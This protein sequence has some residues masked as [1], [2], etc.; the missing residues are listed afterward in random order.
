LVT[1]YDGV[2]ILGDAPVSDGVATLITGLL[3]SGARSLTALYEGGGSMPYAPIVSAVQLQTVNALA[4]DT[5]LASAPIY[6]GGSLYL[7]D[8]VVVNDF[9]GDG[10]QDLA[11]LTSHTGLV[12]FLGNGSGGFTPAAGGPYSVG[13]NPNGIVA[14]DFNGDGIPDLA[15]TSSGNNNMTVLLGNG[16]GTFTAAS[17]SPFGVGSYPQGLAVGDFNGDGIAD[18][19]IAASSSYQVTVLL[20]NGTGGFTAASGSPIAVNYPTAVAVADFNGDGI[21]DI[22]VAEGQD[23][24]VAVFLGNGQGGFTSAGSPTPVGNVPWAMVT[25]DFNGDGKADLAVINYEG[26]NVTVLLGNGTGG[27]AQSTG[28]P[29]EVGPYPFTIASGDF[30]GD[31][32][33]DLAVSI[34]GNNGVAILLGNGSGGFTSPAYSP[35][36]PLVGGYAVAVGQFNGDGHTDLAVGGYNSFEIYAA[37]AVPQLQITHQPSSGT[38]GAA[39]GNVVVQVNDVNGNLMTGSTAQITLSSN[40]AGVGGTVTVNASGG[41][42]TFS[43]LVFSAAG[44]FVLT[45]SSPGAV[46][47]PAGSTIQIAAGSQTISF[48]AISSQSMGTPVTL[49]AT[50]SSG[51]TVNFASL[52]STVCAVSGNTATLLKIGKCKIQAMQPGN[53]NYLAATPVDQSFEVTQGSQTI[54]F[55]PPANQPYGTPPFTLT[56]TAS[57]GLT[58]KYTSTTTTVCTVSGATVTLLKVGKCTIRASQA[59]NANWAAA[60]PVTESFQVTKDSQ[61]ITFGSLPNVPLSTGS[62]TVGATA[63]SGLTVAFAS[64]TARVCTVSGTKVTLI[65]TGTCTIKATQ[66]GNADYAAA[67]PVDQSFQVTANP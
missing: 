17:G 44:S 46:S 41:I 30:N 24:V 65:K 34:T 57:S 56:A 35:L 20:G 54:T 39:F 29:F 2:T 8:S 16:D 22:A 61:T 10:Y 37:E 67:A 21:A 51:L 66:P 45:A 14:A 19:A 33:P 26:S 49:N 13:S 6:F 32:H 59:G 27:F 7:T 4:A 11:I 23:N 31:G 60:T 9:N 18:L 28:S 62:I 38:V 47:S 25:A 36:Q 64:A 1:F 42:A 63:S 52:T 50:A 58:V 12:I 15:I 48:G 43:S 5:L 3:S 55:G 40:P 53:A